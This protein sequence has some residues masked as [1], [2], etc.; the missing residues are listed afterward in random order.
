MQVSDFPQRLRAVVFDV[1]GTLYHAGRLRNKMMFH[2]L[3]QFTGRP[4]EG[5]RAIRLLRVYRSELERLRDQEEPCDIAAR[6]LEACRQ[7]TGVAETAVRN[8]I[9]TLFQ[10]APL[11]FL[12]E[13]IY[14]GLRDFLVE[15]RK[16]GV[17]L[18]IVSDYPASAKLRALGLDGLFE[19]VLP[20]SYPF[21]GKLK[22]HPLGLNLCL[23]QLQVQPSEAIYIG[24]RAD[25]DIPCALRA[26][27]HPVL[28]GAR[29]GKGC[30]S[31][32]NYRQLHD[33]C[34]QAWSAPQVPFAG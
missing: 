34:R 26:G 3:R 2:M 8:V 6:Q 13:C 19:V 18:G 20:A 30:S 33:L 10:E 11:K 25:V 7:Q 16:A 32:S 27:V 15:A 4:R 24:D 28:I 31:I 29:R 12:P 22:P 9:T 14:P 17:R 1:D 21:I 5:T 23:E